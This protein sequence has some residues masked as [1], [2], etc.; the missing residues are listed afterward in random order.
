MIRKIAASLS[1][2]ILFTG[3]IPEY[4]VKASRTNIIVVKQKDNQIENNIKYKIVNKKTNLPLIV[5]SNNEVS[6]SDGKYE[7]TEIDNK[8]VSP[9]SFD[10]PY[11]ENGKTVTKLT[12][13]PKENKVISKRKQN[14]D[15]KVIKQPISK[16]KKDLLTTNEKEAVKNISIIGLILIIIAAFIYFLTN[17]KRGTSENAK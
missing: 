2:F 15:K 14:N 16:K 1:L 17:G 12:I 11:K 7:L 5:S 4:S 10:L 13:Y 6:L 9:I 8:N 3:I